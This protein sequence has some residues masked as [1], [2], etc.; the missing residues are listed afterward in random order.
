MKRKAKAKVLG[1]W[2]KILHCDLTNEDSEECL[3]GDCDVDK[4]VIRIEESLSDQEYKRVL[5]HEMFHMKVGLSGLREQL[6]EELE[7]SL[8]T[9]M[10]ID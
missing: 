1:Q 6:D 2:I 3:L 9:L 10:E 4:R 5:R 7:E 8:A